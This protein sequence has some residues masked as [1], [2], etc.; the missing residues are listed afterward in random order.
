MGLLK[1]KR[2][3]PEKDSGLLNVLNN[4]LPKNSLVI[5]SVLKSSKAIVLPLSKSVDYLLVGFL[6]V[7]FY[8]IVRYYY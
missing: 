4:E 7:V 3:S 1:P 2:A 5:N 8:N 6:S